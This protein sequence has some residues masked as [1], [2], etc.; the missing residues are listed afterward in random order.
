VRISR[1][2]PL[3]A[4]AEILQPLIVVEEGVDS[5]ST[6]VVTVH[7]ANN[8]SIPPVINLSVSKSNVLEHF[9]LDSLLKPILPTHAGSLLLNAEQS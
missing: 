1:Q 4:F 6:T 7:G 5:I 2:V 9:G 3:D 8:V